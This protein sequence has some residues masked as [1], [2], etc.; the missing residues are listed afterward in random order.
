MCV[1]LI[2]PVIYFMF[3]DANATK[4]SFTANKLRRACRDKNTPDRKKIKRKKRESESISNTNMKKEII[5][6][7]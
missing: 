4:R 5:A 7:R 6:T 1:C 3:K 2:V